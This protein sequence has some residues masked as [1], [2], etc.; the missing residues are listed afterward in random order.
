MTIDRNISS[1]L[2]FRP[3]YLLVLCLAVPVL[4][5]GCDLA[6]NQLKPDRAANKEVQDFR[7]GLAPR[8]PEVDASASSA[9]ASSIPSLQPYV[10]QGTERLKAMPLVSISVNQSVPLRDVLFELAQQADFDLELDPNIRGSIIFTARNRPFDQVIERISAVAGL[11]YKF[12]EDYLRV[13]LDKPYNKVYKVDYLSYIRTN[14]GTVRSDVNVVSGDGA[15]TGSSF[16]ATS[17]SEADFWGELDANIAQIIGG[18]SESLVTRRDPRIRVTE[19]NPDVAVVAETGENGQVQVS[20]PDAVLNVD[21]L[22]IDD[23]DNNQ[24][25]NR[26]ESDEQESG[27]AVNRQAGLISIFTTQKKHAEVEEYLK[28]VRKSVTAQVLIEAKIVEVTLNDEYRTGIDWNQTFS[29][30]IVSGF[31]G[32]A[33][34]LANTSTGTLPALASGQ[35]ISGSSNFVLGAIGNDFQALVQAIQGF[36]TVRALASP[37]LTVLNNQSAVLN[38]ATNQV[39]FEIDIDVTA[40]D[41]GATQTD[42]DSDIRNVPEGILVNVQPSINL[43]NQTVALAVRPTI[44]TVVDEVSDPAVQFITAGLPPGSPTVESLIPE[45]NVQE[46]DSVIQVRSGQAVVMGGLLQDR[47]ETTEEGIP[48]LSE[49]PFVG[50][51]FRNH[52][53]LVQKTELVI[54]LKATILDSPGQSVHNTDRDIYRQFSGDRRPFKL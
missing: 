7:D 38:V 22:P 46:I 36:G 44:T 51:A 29:G 43:D 11:R 26:G 10:A 12:E 54:L 31:T 42:I 18:A 34:N 17:E 41:G 1:F 15:D 27:F 14:S 50:A 4:V 52:S 21:A 35:V 45:L 23:E 9:S 37:R 25:N 8:L 32:N 28:L 39:F 30:D 5:S 2:T 48:V 13:E 6:K 19:Q 33:A 49:L 53:D 47:S 40:T 3:L 24:S 20:A 16:E